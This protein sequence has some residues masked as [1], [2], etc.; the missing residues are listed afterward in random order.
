MTYNQLIEKFRD[1]C[2]RHK[3]INTFGTGEEWESEGILKPGIKYQL[4]YTI[5]IDSAPLTQTKNRRFEILC[6]DIVNKDK[7]NEQEVISDTEQTLDDFVRFCRN[8]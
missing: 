6:F 2:T 3:F 1:F 4:F 5:P 8:T 7:S